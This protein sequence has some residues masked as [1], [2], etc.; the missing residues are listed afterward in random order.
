MSRTL[1]VLAKAPWAGVSKTRLQAEARL[2]PEA[3]ARLLEGFVRDVLAACA[4]VEEARLEIHAAP[5]GSE[6]LFRELAPQAAVHAQV[7]GDLGARMQAAFEVAFAAG[8][9]AAVLIGTDAPHLGAETLRTAF[10]ALERADCTLVPAEDGG[11]A[12]LGCSRWSP[13]LL[14]GVEWSSERVLAQTLERAARAGLSVELLAPTF[15]V[16]RAADLERL[17]A[18]LAVDPRRA[19][20][21][22]AALR[23]AGRA[24]Q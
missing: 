10:A 11:Y 13:G 21:T 23:A 22:A 7:D 18:L 4:A 9:R 2:G 16:D 24:P 6:A 17:A 14:D 1:L 3:L 15:D 19:P 20:A 12:L 8:A 5:P